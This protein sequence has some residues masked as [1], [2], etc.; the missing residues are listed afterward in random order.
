MTALSRFSSRG[1]TVER[2]KRAEFESSLFVDVEE[3]AAGEPGPPEDQPRYHGRPWS[4]LRDAMLAGGATTVSE[5]PA[6]AI[7]TFYRSTKAAGGVMSAF[8]DLFDGT[9]SN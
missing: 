2:V 8:K 4:K 3:R 1:P 9:P 7:A 5:L 6:H